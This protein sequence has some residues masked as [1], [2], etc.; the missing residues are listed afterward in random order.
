MENLSDK[1]ISTKTEF[2]EL[3]YVGAGFSELNR[4]LETIVKVFG[5]FLKEDLNVG[6]KTATLSINL[7]DDLTIRELNR[8]YRSKDKIT[9]VLS[10]PMQ[11]N[12]RAGDFD[13][14]LPELEIGD[15][16]IC[17]SVCKK[18][19]SEFSIEFYEEFIHL[20]VHG[21]LHLCGYDH[22]I[23]EEEE[24]LMEKLEERLLNEISLQK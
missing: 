12:L 13:K 23:N 11:E 18:Q 5:H 16:F 22:E 10:F 21:F 24:K 17:N 8:D 3:S 14:F 7:C 4:S 1:E 15:I 9:D 19:A 2:L 6:D 20:A